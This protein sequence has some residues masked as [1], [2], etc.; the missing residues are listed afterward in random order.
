MA[1]NAQALTDAVLRVAKAIVAGAGTGV[2]LYLASTSG[3]VS[4]DE[5]EKIVGSFVVVAFLT[6]LT[7]NKAPANVVAKLQAKF[8]KK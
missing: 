1:A 6:W 3:G 5:W 7:P 8:N 4:V 2:T